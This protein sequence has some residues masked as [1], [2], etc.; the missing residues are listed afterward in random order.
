[1][2]EGLSSTSAHTVF[3]KDSTGQTTKR[4]PRGQTVVVSQLLQARTLS[5]WTSVTAVC[6]W[7]L[8]SSRRVPVLATAHI[9]V[10]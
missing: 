9:D 7:P 6:Y 5:T 10:A 2:V 4:L 3:V 1:M 8:T